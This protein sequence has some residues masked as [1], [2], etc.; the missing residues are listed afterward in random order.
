MSFDKKINKN[1]LLSFKKL[2]SLIHIYNTSPCY[3]KD[4]KYDSNVIK[5]IMF[6][7]FHDNGYNYEKNDFN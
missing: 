2:Q 6:T 1:S 5:N 4:Y 7:P 3:K